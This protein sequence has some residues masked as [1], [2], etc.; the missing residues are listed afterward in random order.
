MSSILTFPTKFMKTSKSKQ[1]SELMSTTVFLNE[2]EFSTLFPSEQF[3]KD[4][5]DIAKWMVVHRK[6]IV[7]ILTEK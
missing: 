1:L 3:D 4:I 2:P 5:D 7:S 6:K